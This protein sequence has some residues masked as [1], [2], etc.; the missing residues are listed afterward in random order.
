MDKGL[1]M[2]KLMLAE[3]EKVGL[4]RHYRND[5]LVHDLNCIREMES[6]GM[7]RF[8][9]RLRECGTQF[10]SHS[11]KYVRIGW[12]AEQDFTYVCD[13]DAGTI[14]RLPYPKSNKIG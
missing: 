4:P 2:H 8:W 3:A 11:E 10:S 13:I 7:S 5:L 6:K 9:W 14:E 1:A 12:D